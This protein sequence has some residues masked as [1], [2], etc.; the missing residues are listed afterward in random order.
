MGVGIDWM[1]FVALWVA[2]LPGA[3]GRIAAFGT[4]PLLVGTAGLVVLCLLRSPLRFAGAVVIGIAAVAAART[5]QP[6]VLIAGSGDSVA[7]RDAD[8]RL[9]M[10]RSGG[11]TF[12][13]REWLAADGDARTPA[14][15]QKAGGF[16]CD[17]EG[18]VARLADGKPVAVA[19]SADALA[20]DCARAALVVTM[21]E[22]PP[23]CAATVIDRKALRA[24]GALA[25]RRAG[26]G[27]DLTASR[28]PGE[29][30]PWAPAS[31]PAAT[32]PRTPAQ[33][34]PA[35]RDAT[36]NPDDLDAE[37]AGPAAAP[38]D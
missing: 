27:W 1:S 14:Q 29:T 21:R 24:G 17:D 5:P 11:P 32:V 16:V 12:A 35:P 36:P 38:P 4:G 2:S 13:I 10:W 18:C 31:A 28:Q 8:G 23:D 15:A 7:V 34:R 20:D 9:R 19:T 30:R 25:L 33:S 3:V 26:V 22:A 6:D 37:D